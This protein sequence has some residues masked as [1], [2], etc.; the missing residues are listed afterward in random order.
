[1]IGVAAGLASENYYPWVYTIIPFLIYRPYEF[2]E[3]LVCHQNLNVKLVGVGSGLAYDTLGY[4]HYG[5]EDLSLLKN[6]PNLDIYLPYDPT[7][8]K[9]FE[10]AS[11]VKILVI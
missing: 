9:C 3:N 1:M 7:A 5:L 10:L 6:L 2:V 4:T 8:I 11:E